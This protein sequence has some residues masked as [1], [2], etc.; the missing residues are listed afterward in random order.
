MV[1]RLL[2]AAALTLW[3]AACTT[4][5]PR[6]EP[7]PDLPEPGVPPAEPSSIPAPTPSPTPTP[8]PQPRSQATQALLDGA[9]TDLGAG[10]LA[11]ASIKLER[12]LRLSPRDGWVWHELA[13]V[14]LAEG[15]AAQARA[16]LSR[17]NALAGP[18][19]VL[20]EHNERLLNTA[21]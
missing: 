11:D 2:V 3:I 14:R 8:L 12:A 9:R 17:S 13:R 16:L 15:D 10:R 1:R 20:R 4:P 18:D 5:P 6:R 7:P 21:R 19:E